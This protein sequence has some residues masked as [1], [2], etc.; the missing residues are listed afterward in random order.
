MQ[1]PLFVNFFRN[2]QKILSKNRKCQALPQSEIFTN[3]KDSC[4]NIKQHPYLSRDIG[5]HAEVLK[6][7]LRSIESQYK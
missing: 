2:C 5:R 6:V 3:E 4:I 1:R 7:L